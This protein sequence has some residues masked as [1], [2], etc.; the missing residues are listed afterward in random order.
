LYINIVL[1]DG[2]FADISNTTATN[3]AFTTHLAQLK[4]KVPSGFTII[5]Q[6]PFVVI[7]DESPEMVQLRATNVVKWAVDKLK[8]DYFKDDPQEII[9]I[10]LFRDQ[11]SYLK[12]SKQLFND[13]PTTPFGYY[14]AQDKSLIMNAATGGGTLVHEIVHPFMRANFPECPPW[15]NEGFASLYEQS[16]ERNGHI[17]GLTNWRLRGLQQAIKNGEII[18]F[19]KLTALN[20]AEFYYENGNSMY[21]DNYAQA[22]YLCYYLQ[23]KGLLIKFYC[24]FTAHAKTDPTGYITLKRVLGENDMERFMKKWETFVLNL[25]FP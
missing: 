24:E 23:E 20:N 11:T 13:T 16:V 8:Q 2:A 25:K 21:N 17:W 18:S 1:A 10:W 12:Y 9:D 4:P 7:G 22:R 5:V 14:S 15:F 19:Q 6:S 3:T